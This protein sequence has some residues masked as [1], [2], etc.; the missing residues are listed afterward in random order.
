M[1]LTGPWKIQH[2]EVGEKHPLELAAPGLDDRFWIGAA[3]PGDVH[4]ALIE[5]RIIDPPYFGHNDAKCR[6]IE[7]KEWWYRTTFT[8]DEAAHQ[9]ERFELVFEGWTPSPKF[10]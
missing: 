5:R 4:S 1:E 2:Y 10:M 8:V 9:D 7:Q 6:W 3:V